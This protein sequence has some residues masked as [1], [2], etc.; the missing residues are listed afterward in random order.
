[1]NVPDAIARFRLNP[2]HPFVN[3]EN[4]QK[5]QEHFLQKYIVAFGDSG[6]W[7]MHTQLSLFDSVYRLRKL[8]EIVNV[9]D[10]QEYGPPSPQQCL[11]IGRANLPFH[12]A[13]YCCQSPST[14]IAEMKKWNGLNVK[15]VL[16]KWKKRKPETLFNVVPT[17]SSHVDHK[18]HAAV[19]VERNVKG[20]QQTRNNILAFT[21]FL[22]DELLASNDYSICA[23]FSHQILYT[24][25]MDVLTYPSVVNPLE[26][27]FAFSPRI[28]ERKELYLDRVYTIE[29]L[30]NNQATIFHIGM[31]GNR[32]V[33]EWY[34]FRDLDRKGDIFMQ[35][36]DDLFRDTIV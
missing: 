1:M 26:I 27:N 14:A 23:N 34:L 11:R 35:A 36:K 33:P 21:L 3:G 22:G 28:L 7:Y 32:T 5:Y 30:E 20:D 31:F 9:N 6:M 16:S 19:V 10:A 4:V 15:Y 12:P 8:E 24:G 13:F 25:K 18:S 29:P 17:Y 2:P